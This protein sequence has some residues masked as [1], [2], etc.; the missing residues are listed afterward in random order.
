MLGQTGDA[1]ST[2]NGQLTE[3]VNWLARVKMKFVCSKL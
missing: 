3:Y 1:V 2:S